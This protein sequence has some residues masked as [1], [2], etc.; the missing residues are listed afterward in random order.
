MPVGCHR[1]GDALHLHPRVRR[2]QA[3][4]RLGYRKRRD[5]QPPQTNRVRQVRDRLFNHEQKETLVFSGR[6]KC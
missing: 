1:R 4:V 5:Q 3:V 6:G 2:S